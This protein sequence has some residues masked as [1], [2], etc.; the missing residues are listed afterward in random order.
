MSIRSF[1][2][3]FVITIIAFTAH[4]GENWPGWRGPTG[5][6]QT[7][8]KNLPL[9]WGGKTQ[10]NVVW[11]SPLF[12][13]DKVE[14]DHN[15]SSPAVWGDR[16][17]VTVSY[18][19]EGVT[20]KDY[21]EHHLLCFSAKHGKK[22]WDTPIQPGPWKLSDFRGGGYACSTP[23]T[24]GRHIYA[25]FGSAVIAAVDFDGA[26][27]WRKEIK[28]HDFDVAFA[29]SPVIHPPPPPQGAGREVK[30]STVILV[31]DQVNKS[32]TIYAFEG[33]TGEIRWESR[34]PKVNWAHSTPLL[35]KIN[36][37]LQLITATH[38]GPQGLDPAT[39]ATLWFFNE[40]KQVGDTVTPI[41]RDGV[42]YVDSGRG[43][44]GIAVDVTGSGDV[45]KTHLK[46]NV[47]KV[48]EGFSSPVLVGDYLYRLHGPG[49]LTCLKWTTGEK[50]FQDRL[51]GVETACSPIA[52]ADGRI[53]CASAGKSYVL[54]A[55][56]TLEI[57]A[58]NDLGDASKAS[59]AVAAGR[60]YLKGA[61][62]LFCVGVK[63]D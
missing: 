11:K 26:I 47:P 56:P 34:R 24:D 39:G 42:V 32:S 5:M 7:D 53:Y 60:I 9:I 31:C 27:A 17:F 10:E 30:R 45:S 44:M 13:S 57:L 41:V 43:G 16:V 23:A 62:Y 33:N 40:L 3:S 8:E 14:R 28:P 6:G 22:L 54:K 15:Q 35:A 59:P 63:K 20:R 1:F 4:A 2:Y 19:P 58:R 25:V 55:G 61:R 37:K 38:N 49:L 51:E 36:N 21:S 29:A 50:V 12:P 52:T 46:W 18:W 48:S